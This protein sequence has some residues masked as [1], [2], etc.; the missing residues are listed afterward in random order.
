M[1]KMSVPGIRFLSSILSIIH[2]P[3]TKTILIFTLGLSKQINKL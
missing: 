3:P 1:Q 2:M